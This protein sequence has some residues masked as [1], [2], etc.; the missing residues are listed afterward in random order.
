MVSDSPCGAVSNVVKSTPAG[1][2]IG[3]WGWWSDET[4]SD[5]AQ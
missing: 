2:V 4:R 5:H 3:Y 1:L